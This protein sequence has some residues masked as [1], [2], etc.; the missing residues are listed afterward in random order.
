M[1][2]KK[3]APIEEIYAQVVEVINKYDKSIWV[4][5]YIGL[6]LQI[7]SLYHFFETQ[8]EM[9]DGYLSEKMICSPEFRVGERI[10]SAMD[11]SGPRVILG[12]LL[13]T[14]KVMETA[15]NFERTNNERRLDS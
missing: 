9:K 2:E 14:T 6:L 12:F 4:G 15:G 13:A 1:D 3:S 8:G 10:A 11:Q 5:N 7:S